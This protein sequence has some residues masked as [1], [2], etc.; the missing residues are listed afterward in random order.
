MRSTPPPRSTCADPSPIAVRA[1]TL[2]LMPDPAPHPLRT[3]HE[4]LDDLDRRLFDAVAVSPSPLLDL[5]M[6]PLSAAADFVGGLLGRGLASGAA[7][8]Q[9]VGVPHADT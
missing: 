6:R 8:G 9:N 4:G 2:A 7:G 3:L 1:S 5:T